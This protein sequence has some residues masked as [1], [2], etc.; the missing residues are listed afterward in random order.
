M[1]RKV[2]TYHSQFEEVANIWKVMADITDQHSSTI[3]TS[4]TN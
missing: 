2:K 1:D 4:R 3:S